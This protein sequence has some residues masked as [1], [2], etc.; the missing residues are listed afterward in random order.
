MIR[1]RMNQQMTEYY[2]MQMECRSSQTFQSKS[3]KEL[4]KLL[5]LS[6]YQHCFY[7]RSLKSILL[8][9]ISRRW[10]WATTCSLTSTRRLRT[11][12]SR[13]LTI[14]SYCNST[15]STTRTISLRCLSTIFQI[16]RTMRRSVWMTWGMM[17]LR[18]RL[19][20]MTMLFIKRQ[21]SNLLLR[22]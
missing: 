16:Q 13:R 8:S 18:S 20:M 11:G 21:N 5:L 6:S 2:L 22:Q 17:R 4:L 9:H 12:H 3:L 10:S 19:G 15:F 1:K 7:Y 14:R